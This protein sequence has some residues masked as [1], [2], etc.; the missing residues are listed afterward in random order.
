M[1]RELREIHVLARDVH[2]MHG[3]FV[4]RHLH[5]GLGVG[6]PPEIFVVELVLAGF[7]RGSQA[8]SAARGLRYDL[9][10]F[11]TRSF[12]QERFLCPFD[13]RA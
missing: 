13:D 5:H 7:E 1:E 9:Q 2:L 10:L 4:G 11:G 8:P 6:E 3:G 12:E